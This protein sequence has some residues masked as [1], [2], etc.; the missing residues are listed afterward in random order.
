LLERFIENAFTFARSFALS[1]HKSAV[2]LRNFRSCISSIEIGDA[3]RSFHLYF[4]VYPFNKTLACLIVQF[5]KHSWVGNRST[6]PTYFPDQ[7]T[8]TV[9]RY[10]LHTTALRSCELWSACGICSLTEARRN[11]HRFRLSGAQIEAMSLVFSRR[12]A[13]WNRTLTAIREWITLVLIVGRTNS[14]TLRSYYTL[15]LKICQYSAEILNKC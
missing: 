1:V 9:V 13:R 10:A 7:R 5:S 3:P 2:E 14:A 8:L 11:L 15:F 12:A 6:W 4:T